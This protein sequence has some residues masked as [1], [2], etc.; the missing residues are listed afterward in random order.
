MIAGHIVENYFIVCLLN[1]TLGTACFS[2]VK[3]PGTA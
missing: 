3:P 2:V 1:D